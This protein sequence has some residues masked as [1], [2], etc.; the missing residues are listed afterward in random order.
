MFP[1]IK[2]VATILFN[3][4]AC[5]HFLYD[6]GAFYRNRECTEC[7]TDMKYYSNLCAFVCPR[8]NCRKRISNRKNTFFS[9]CKLQCSEIMYLAYLWLTDCSVKTT[10]M[11]TGHSPNTVCDYFKYFRKL[12]SSFPMQEDRKIGGEGIVVE[13]DESKLGKRKNHRGHHVEGVWILGGV[14]RTIERKTFMVPVA[15][16]SA[17][18]LLPIIANYVEI[19]SII[20][21]DLWRGYINLENELRILHFTVNHSETF[22]DPDTGVHTN[23]IEGT[24]NGLKIS[25]SPRNRTRENIEIHIG[26]FQ[27]RR[28]NKNNLWDAFIEL[29]INTHYD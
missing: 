26:E 22:V 14:E 5:L 11:H 15:D 2:E 16:R 25:I 21:T 8:K 27:W 3:E 1:N 28:E 18:T 24:W 7:E 4:Y 20:Y 10:M 19:G 9:E 17:A 29:L 6:I 12:V 23:T 13:I